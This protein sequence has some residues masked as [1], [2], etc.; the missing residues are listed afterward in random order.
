MWRLLDAVLLDYQPSLTRSLDL[1]AED[2][3]GRSVFHIAAIHNRREIFSRICTAEFVHYS[4]HRFWHF[5]KKFDKEGLTPPMIMNRNA[6]RRM[7]SQV[8]DEM[9]PR[10]FKDI[11]ASLRFARALK[12]NITAV[13]QVANEEY[14]K[15][16]CDIIRWGH[17][18]SIQDWWHV[19]RASREDSLVLLK[20]KTET[21][22]WR[23]FT[24]PVSDIK[25]LHKLYP[26]ARLLS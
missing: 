2:V 12:L 23:L 22:P 7:I 25:S 16:H 21:R 6:D 24:L 13:N 15:G 17:H 5:I 3:K 26:N 11:N 1:N 19:F 14:A 8:E 20:D 10:I 4:P 9:L 18:R